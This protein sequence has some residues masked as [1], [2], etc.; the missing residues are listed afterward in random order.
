M[1]LGYSQHKKQTI[2]TREYVAYA[3]V[4]DKSPRCKAGIKPV[5]LL[6]ASIRASPLLKLGLLLLLKY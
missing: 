3:Y 4:R 5:S 6:E 2:V 1:H